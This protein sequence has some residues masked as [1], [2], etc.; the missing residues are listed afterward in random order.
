MKR[1]IK[2][3]TKRKRKEY[4]GVCKTGRQRYKGKDIIHYDFEKGTAY[5]DDTG[6]KPFKYGPLRYA[7][8]TLYND[9]LKVFETKKDSGVEIIKEMPTNMS[10][11][12]LYLQR[13][14]LCK[15]TIS[16]AMKLADSYTYFLHLDHLAK[17]LFRNEQKREV[18]FDAQEA[19]EKV[20]TFIS[21]LNG[22]GLVETGCMQA[23]KL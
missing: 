17:W 8:F 18:A 11:R 20:E 2:E 14:G 1:R 16:D 5:M 10:D 21:I 23:Q 13:K 3:D 15:L 7:Q 22:S 4:A 6:V 12:F 9:L 19:K